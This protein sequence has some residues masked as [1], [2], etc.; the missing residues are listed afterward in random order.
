MPSRPTNSISAW[1]EGDCHDEVLRERHHYLHGPD[2]NGRWRGRRRL[3]LRCRQC[4]T[5]VSPEILSASLTGLLG[6][7]NQLPSIK[8]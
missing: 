6:D 7:S 8:T 3:R 2:R 5:A 1:L 4:P